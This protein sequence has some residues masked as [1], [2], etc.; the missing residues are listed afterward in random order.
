[1][2]Y[3]TNIISATEENANFRKVLFTGKKSQLVV[4]NIP[5]G[6][7]I[8]K[9]KHPQV[10]QSLFILSGQA[11]V[12]LDGK[13]TEIN[14]GDVVVVTPGVKHN[15]VN[16]GTELLKV[17][18]VYAPANHLD[19]RIHVTKEEADADAEDEKFGESVPN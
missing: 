11:K 15:I 5:A 10:E 16:T 7:E 2:S 9:E 13:E 14:V 6:G 19:G 4:M 18:T 3:I 1:M 17:Y 8:G 12:T